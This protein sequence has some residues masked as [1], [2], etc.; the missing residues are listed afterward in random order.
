MPRSPGDAATR[1]WDQTE[2]RGIRVLKRAWPLHF[3]LARGFSPTNNA[4]SQH[5]E[6]ARLQSRRKHPIF[7][8]ALA[9]EGI[10]AREYA[11]F[12]APSSAAPHLP[13]LNIEVSRLMNC[14]AAC[15]SIATQRSLL[16]IIR[17][18]H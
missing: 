2:N 12:S 6:R 11:A 17:M 4:H 8:V 10:Y 16:R 13:P 1:I 18:D 5:F 3:G 14:S 9:T 15:G 7:S